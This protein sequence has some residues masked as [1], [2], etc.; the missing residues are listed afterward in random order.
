MTTFD[1]FMTLSGAQRLAENVLVK[2]EDAK[3]V[4]PTDSGSR[5]VPSGGVSGQILMWASDGEAAWGDDPLIIEVSAN[6]ASADVAFGDV[7]AMLDAHGSSIDEALSS[8][9]TIEG[10]VSALETETSTLD[11]ELA[12][13]T[14]TADEALAVA[15]AAK[16]A[17]D[18]LA[19]SKK[20]DDAAFQTQDG[21]LL[22]TG[23]VIE[24]DMQLG[25][26]IWVTRANGNMALKWVGGEA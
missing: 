22:I 19:E 11:S 14:A 12:N 9:T 21:K 6:K 25:S 10:Q 26:W 5:H 1:K 16:T 13:T 20:E 3:Y 15:Q 23:A 7:G 18:E 8:I 2:I 17:V 24:Q 4:H